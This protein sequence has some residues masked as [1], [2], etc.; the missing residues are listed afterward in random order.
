M[1]KLSFRVHNCP[2]SWPHRDS[3]LREAVWVLWRHPPSPSGDDVSTQQGSV[4][5]K[6][7][8][9]DPTAFIQSYQ[10]LCWR[11]QSQTEV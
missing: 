9:Q 3:P 10:W 1:S 5:T 6:L 11:H 4:R 7:L 2:H 8:V